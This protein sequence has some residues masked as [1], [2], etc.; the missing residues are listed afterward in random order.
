MPGLRCAIIMI[1]RS[2]VRTMLA[3][4]FPRN[5]S[6]QE[7][8]NA[9]PQCKRAVAPAR[10]ESP[11]ESRTAIRK[12]R[13]KPRK[14]SNHSDAREVELKSQAESMAFSESLAKAA[15]RNQ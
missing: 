6:L 8:Q 5:Q 13:T 14:L 4:A 15:R 9:S 1:T 11:G 7:T 12:K 3:S 10:A 2:G